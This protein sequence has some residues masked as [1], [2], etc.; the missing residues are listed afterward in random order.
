MDKAGLAE[1]V[2][3]SPEASCLEAQKGM[4]LFGNHIGIG[5]DAA[6]NFKDGSWCHMGSS[7]APQ[8]PS[9]CRSAPGGGGKGHWPLS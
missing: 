3:T 2:A 5:G 7:V 1:G 9:Q 4:L 6:G 8:R